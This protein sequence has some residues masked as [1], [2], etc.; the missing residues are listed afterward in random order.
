MTKKQEPKQVEE[1]TRPSTTTQ[2]AV[3]TP[4][5][6]LRQQ[7]DLQGLVVL[8]DHRA[9]ARILGVLHN[10]PVEVQLAFGNTP[11]LVP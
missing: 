5:P 4:S 8:G 3:Q 11:R 1:Y 6:S 10:E 2:P 7:S 9:L